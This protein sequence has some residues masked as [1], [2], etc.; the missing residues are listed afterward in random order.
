MITMHP[1]E[2]LAMSYVEP[3]KIS[4]AQLSVGLGLPLLDIERLL[5]KEIELTAEMGLA[6]TTRSR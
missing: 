5:A 6:F 1:G 3:Y 4:P 2:Y